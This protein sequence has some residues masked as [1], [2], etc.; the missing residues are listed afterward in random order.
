MHS[1]PVCHARPAPQAEAFATG[2][3]PP[4]AATTFA[5]VEVTPRGQLRSLRCPEA[6]YD[7]GVSYRQVWLYERTTRRT[8]DL[9][10]VPPTHPERRPAQ[11]SPRLRS[12]AGGGVL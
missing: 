1:R 8:Y 9:D 12:L 5:L 2:D 10:V 11:S 6:L 3:A 7:T 4:G